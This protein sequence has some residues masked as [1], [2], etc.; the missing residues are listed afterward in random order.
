MPLPSPSVRTLLDSLPSRARLI[1]LARHVGVF[2]PEKGTRAE[3]ESRD[4]PATLEA[5]YQVSLKRLVP[6]GLVYL[7]PT[8]SL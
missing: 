2:V 3:T 6:V 4:E 7:W 5:L 1:E 8:T